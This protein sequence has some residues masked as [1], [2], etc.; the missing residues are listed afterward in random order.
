M[1]MFNSSI[2][3]KNIPIFLEYKRIKPTRIFILVNGSITIAQKYPLST[4]FKVSGIFQSFITSNPCDED[5]V[6]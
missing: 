3:F 1:F 4:I 5:C 6:C 2:Y